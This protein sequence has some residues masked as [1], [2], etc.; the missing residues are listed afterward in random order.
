MEDLTEVQRLLRL[1]R[2]EAPA[3]D[4]FENFL[5]E[6]QDRQRAEMLKRPLWRLALDRL[7]GAMPTFQVSQVAYAGSC[8]LALLIAGVSSERILTSP[9]GATTPTGAAARPAGLTAAMSRHTTAAHAKID[10]YASKPAFRLSELDFN[11]PRPT[12]A[13]YTTTAAS[14]RYVLDSH[15]ASY[16]QPYSF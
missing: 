13:A 16:G 3:P 11:Q 1:K 14:P 6:F 12:A 9:V 4:Y 10:F 2:Y 15:P 5:S 8:A 7:E